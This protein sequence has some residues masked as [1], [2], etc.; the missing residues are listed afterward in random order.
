MASQCGRLSKNERSPTL[1]PKPL[2]PM[3]AAAP[4][5]TA[6]TVNPAIAT[7]ASLYMAS[8]LNGVVCGIKQS[9]VQPRITDQHA[10]DEVHRQQQQCAA[11][12]RA[13]EQPHAQERLHQH[14]A[15]HVV[16]NER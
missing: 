8:S 5:Q 15:Q 14:V 10:R 4:I 12:N 13:T 7:K 11:A 6:E 2:P 1:S 9:V 16:R 3:A